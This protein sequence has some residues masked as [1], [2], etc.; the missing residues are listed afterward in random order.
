[1]HLMGL[2]LYSPESASMYGVR[3][4]NNDLSNV[5][6]VIVPD[7]RL[8]VSSP[9]ILKSPNSSVAV[10]YTR[11]KFG[12]GDS[13]E[14]NTISFAFFGIPP[15]CG[16]AANMLVPDPTNSNVCDDALIKDLWWKS[17]V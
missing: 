5:C 10:K 8:I 7:S 15:F 2:P 11:P 9:P 14:S 1:M 16:I 17:V 3:T 6:P 4:A 12:V 13:A